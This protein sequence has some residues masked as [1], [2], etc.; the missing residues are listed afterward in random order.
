M[1]THAPRCW[2]LS[3]AIKKDQHRFEKNQDPGEPRLLTD[4]EVY[5]ETEVI[6]GYLPLNST[7]DKKIEE[8]AREIMNMGYAVTIEVDAEKD[9]EEAF[10]KTT[11][12]FWEPHVHN[13]PSIRLTTRGSTYVDTLDINGRMIRIHLQRP[14]EYAILPEG[15]FHRVCPDTNKHVKM[16]IMFYDKSGWNQ[17]KY[18]EGDQTDS[19]KRYKD[20]MLAVR[21][22]LDFPYKKGPVS[23]NAKL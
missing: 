12:G 7:D 15:N 6:V 19:Y 13:Q 9:G 16:C 3:P 21:R 5:I 10:E 20:R 22:S 11:E 17:H 14:G 4:E 18:P 23:V 2:Y 1:A 8:Q